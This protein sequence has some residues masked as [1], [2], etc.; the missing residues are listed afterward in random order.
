MKVERETDKILK[1][2]ENQIIKVYSN[3]FKVMKKEMADIMAKIGVME[4]KPLAEKMVL[5]NKHNRFDKLCKDIALEIKNANTTA[6]GYVNS[7]KGNIYKINYNDTAKRL[8]MP[9][10]TNLEVKE[11]LKEKQ[12]PFINIAV[13]EEKDKNSIERK[14]KSEML[15]GMLLG[16]GISK[17]T[18]RLKNNTN[19]Y[20]NKTVGIARGNTTTYENE[21]INDAGAKAE[22]QGNKVWKRWIAVADDRT[23]PFH[24]M[25][26]GREKPFNEPFYINGEYLMYPSDR[27][28]GATDKNIINCRCRIEIFVKK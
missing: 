8:N 22:Q 10:L 7:I 18:E 11:H 3:A 28:L 23:R 15:T 17:L 12:N 4:N 13:E 26:D 9:L 19:K 25:A 27:S 6:L 5:I 20:A 2:T 1:N 24:A 14:I 21:G 16:E